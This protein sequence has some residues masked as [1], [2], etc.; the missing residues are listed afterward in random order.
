MPVEVWSSRYD[1]STKYLTADIVFSML[2]THILTDSL[3]YPA[4]VPGKNL[5]VA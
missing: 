4:A 2:A 5:T 1:I 3:T